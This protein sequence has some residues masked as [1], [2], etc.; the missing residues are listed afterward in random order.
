M[1]NAV[2]MLGKTWLLTEFNI[3]YSFG[4]SLGANI[5]RGTELQKKKQGT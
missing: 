5:T 4:K 2:N 3:C 1:N